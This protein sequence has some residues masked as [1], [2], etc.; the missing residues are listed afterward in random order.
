MLRITTRG[1][2]ACFD[3][4]VVP[5][6]SRSAVVG[7]HSDCVKV[8]LAA[9]PVDGAANAAL[10]ELFAKLL[11]CPQRNVVIV[12]GESSRKKTLAVEGMSAAALEARLSALTTSA[13]T[14]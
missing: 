5:R 8:A 2:A 12:R 11:G 4:H 14:R 9:P 6:A 7:L 10:L 3:V 13:K 1:S